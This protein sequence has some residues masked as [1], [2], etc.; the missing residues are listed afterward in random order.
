MTTNEK[1]QMWQFFRM[2]LT[3]ALYR[4]MA[5]IYANAKS[6]EETNMAHNECYNYYLHFIGGRPE[7]F[8]VAH[9]PIWQK[10]TDRMIGTNLSKF[11]E[12]TEQD[13]EK[14][15]S[16]ETALSKLRSFKDK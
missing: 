10:A 6:N 9:D 5:D 11:H 1:E 16:L 8:K 13:L 12:E 15:K 2:Q 14:R 4:A 3:A 7:W